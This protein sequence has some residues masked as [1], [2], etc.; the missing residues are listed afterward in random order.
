MLRIR[1]SWIVVL[2]CICGFSGLSQ[3]ASE[4]T[5]SGHSQAF[6]ED[7][8]PGQREIS[9]PTFDISDETDRQVVIAQGTSQLRQG[10]VNTVLLPDG[11]T[12]FAAWTV[13]HGGAVRFLKKSDD[14]GLTWSDLLDIPENWPEHANCPPL[15]LLPD[16]QGNERLF[17]FANRGPQGFIMYQAT[18][19]DGGET[20]SPF[21]P[22]RSANGDGLLG[23][24]EEPAPTVM[25]FTAVEPVDGGREL[26]GVTNHRRPGEGGRTNVVTQARSTDGGETWSDWEIILDLG[27]PYRPCEP[28]L[29]RSPDGKQLLMIIRENRRSFN[30][31]IM[32]SNDE[33]RTWSDPYQSTAS[34]TMDRHQHRYAKD[35][36][37]VI[38]GRDVAASSPARRH[39]VAWVGRF[40]DLLEGN[41]GEYRVK[42]LPHH[43]GRDVEYPAIEI[44][45]D[46]VFV[47]T[48]TVVYRP[49][50]NYSVVNTRFTL[51]ELDGKIIAEANK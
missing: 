21:E 2:G 49:G 14:A 48:N 13:G 47:A 40:E 22:S 37:L 7:L 30:S 17:T 8:T 51:E 19:E 15:Y 32:L 41:D 26:L 5:H 31:W 11:K 28:D 18:S 45:P 43:G 10:H 44:L 39:F 29:I 50:E 12:M 42:L 23:E 1:W 25:P 34:V 16:P 24:G 36:R 9:I 4:R 35:G 27:E 38:V 46:G 3:G 33:G 6:I 20:W